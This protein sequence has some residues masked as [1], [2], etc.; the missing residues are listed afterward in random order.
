MIAAAG[1]DFR[2]RADAINERI[3]FPGQSRDL[4]EA[5]RYEAYAGLCEKGIMPVVGTDHD[6][7]LRY[8]KTIRAAVRSGKYAR[9]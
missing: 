5:Q 2:K 3:V 8:G 9:L 6:L 7:S 4:A 1:R